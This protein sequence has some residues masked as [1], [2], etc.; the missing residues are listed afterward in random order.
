MKRFAV[1][2]R[3]LGHR[4]EDRGLLERALTHRSHRHEAGDGEALDYERLEFLGDSLLGF[5]V[6]ERLMVLDAAAD[7]GTLTRRKQAVVSQPTLASAS[8]RLGLGTALKLGRGEDA[9]G[10]R[11]KPSLLADVFESVLAA[12]YLDRK[13]QAGWPADRLLPLLAGL[14]EL[15]PWL[16]Q[17][18]DEPKPGYMGTPAQFFAGLIDTELGSLGSDRS[19]LTNLRGVEEL[20]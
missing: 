20:A 18:H 10:G 17:W 19:T 7:E 9:T 13:Q 15:E 8:R 12:V 16:K 6:S 5:F 1:L 14:A 4:F 3:R 11:G 2:E